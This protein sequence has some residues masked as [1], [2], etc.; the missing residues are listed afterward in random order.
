MVEKSILANAMDISNIK[1]IVLVLQLTLNIWEFWV[2]L[3]YV[4]VL[5]ESYCLS[6][7]TCPLFKPISGSWAKFLSFHF[8]LS[9]CIHVFEV[10]S[11][12]YKLFLWKFSNYCW[13]G[14]FD[15]C[16]NIFQRLLVINANTYI[17]ILCA[18]EHT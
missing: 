5:K 8:K 18:F 3:V 7:L 9:S 16:K 10:T 12:W 14:F 13:A 2:L 6:P 1:A 17:K 11:L 4:I 15:L